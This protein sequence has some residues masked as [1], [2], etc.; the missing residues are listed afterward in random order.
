MRWGRPSACRG[1]FERFF[2]P[3]GT[4]AGPR[5]C[6]AGSGPGRPPGRGQ[7]D[8]ALEAMSLACDEGAPLLLFAAT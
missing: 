2:A 7:R 6:G 5:G 4:H 1:L 3:G 8:Q